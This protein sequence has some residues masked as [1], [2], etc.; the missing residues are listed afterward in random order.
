MTDNLDEPRFNLGM[1]LGGRGL[2]C[3][4]LVNKKR[5]T[6]AAESEMRIIYICL[7]VL[8]YEKIRCGLY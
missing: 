6:L 3:L 7:L 5:K 2:Y 8:D 4:P 1:A